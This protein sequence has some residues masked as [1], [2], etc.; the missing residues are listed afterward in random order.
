VLLSELRE[1]V[2]RAC[3]VALGQWFGACLHLHIEPSV[4]ED[5]LDIFVRLD[6]NGYGASTSRQHQATGCVEMLI[7][8]PAVNCFYSPELGWI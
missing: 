3:D 1:T 6:D 4:R 8:K 7:E 5:G 2:D